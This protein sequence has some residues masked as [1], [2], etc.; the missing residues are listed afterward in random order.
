MSKQYGKHDQS[1]RSE[2][3]EAYVRAIL[4]ME[5]GIITSMASRNMPGYDLVAHNLQNGK[6]CKISVKFRRAINADGF[7]GVGNQF[8][9]DYLVGIVGN[10]GMIG[11]RVIEIDPRQGF[12]GSRVHLSQSLC[13]GKL[14]TTEDLRLAAESDEKTNTQDIRKIRRCLAF[15]YRTSRL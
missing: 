10:R 13:S 3:A 4:M 5:F 1:I 14:Q 15:D 9:Y 2:G 6:S 11:D 12:Q 8:D 7:R